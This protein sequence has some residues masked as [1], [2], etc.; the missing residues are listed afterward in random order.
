MGGA[1]Y[2]VFLIPGL[3]EDSFQRPLMLPSAQFQGHSVGKICLCVHKWDL[4]CLCLVLCVQIGVCLCAYAW[5]CVCVCVCI[6]ESLCESLCVCA[7]VC[8]CVHV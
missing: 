4:L 6:Y 8:V 7:R 1:V 3:E 5:I 2:R